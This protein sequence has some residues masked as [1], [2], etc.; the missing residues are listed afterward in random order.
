MGKQLFVEI[1][2]MGQDI[3]VIN[4]KLD[5][6]DQSMAQIHADLSNQVTSVRDELVDFRAQVANQNDKNEERL[7]KLE[8]AEDLS[9]SI[10]DQ[11]PPEANAQDEA[12]LELQGEI[13][14]LRAQVLDQ[15]GSRLASQDPSSSTV[16]EDIVFLKAEIGSL[17]SSNDQAHGTFD[18]L[19]RAMEALSK[20][21]ASTSQKV[22]VIFPPVDPPSQPPP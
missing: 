3:K 4:E 21:Q 9:L 6:K 2:S 17:K 11:P 15:V 20:E 22:S 19:E 14:A 5:Q 13:D 18:G 16:H 1:K 7:K 8:D 10:S 12:M